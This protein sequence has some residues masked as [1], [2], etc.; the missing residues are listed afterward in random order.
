MPRSMVVGLLA[1]VGAIMSAIVGLAHGDLMPAMIACAGAATGVAA[2]L[3]ASP[4]SKKTFD[5]LPRRRVSASRVVTE[6]PHAA[7][8]AVGR[9]LSRVGVAHRAA[10]P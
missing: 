3:A 8:L 4:A 9:V 2:Y 6:Y 5:R 7:L 1:A 10:T